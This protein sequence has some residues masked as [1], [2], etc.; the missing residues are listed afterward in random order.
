ME[1]TRG[2]GDVFELPFAGHK[3]RRCVKYRLQWFHVDFI[4]AVEHT[5]T[6]VYVDEDVDVNER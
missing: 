5:V 6:V 3:S 4:D 1:G 2:A